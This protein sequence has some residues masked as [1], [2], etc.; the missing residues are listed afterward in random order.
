[1]D[2]VKP[3]MFSLIS[4]NLIDALANW[5]LIF[6]NWGFPAMGVA[7]AGWSTCVSRCYMAIVLAAYILRRE[8]SSP[9]GLFVAVSW[10]PDF[11][12]IRNI[13]TL[14]LPA[15]AQIV[16][17]VGVFASATTLMGRLDRS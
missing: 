8:R 9:T 3:V 15:A 14:G 11:E 1:M 5:V 13:A 2:L 17:E 4:A 7:G 16:M 12:R 10:R 6:G